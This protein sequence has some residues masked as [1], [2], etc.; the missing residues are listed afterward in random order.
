MFGARDE[1]AGRELVGGGYAWIVTV[2]REATH[3]EMAFVIGVMRAGEACT[4]FHESFTYRWRALTATLAVLVIDPLHAV[5]PASILF[6][7]LSKCLEKKGA[8]EAHFADTAHETHFAKAEGIVGF[9]D[10][11]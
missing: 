10:F 7:P 4:A 3:N 1:V 6:H 9:F 5:D 2:S 11:L 8:F